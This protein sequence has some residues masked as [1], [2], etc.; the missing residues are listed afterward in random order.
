M[1]THYI[2]RSCG[3]WQSH[4]SFWEHNAELQIATTGR[5]PS[6]QH[7]TSGHAPFVWDYEPIR[8]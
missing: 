6:L 8:L 5:Y 2:T 1:L 3:I 7:A 4:Y